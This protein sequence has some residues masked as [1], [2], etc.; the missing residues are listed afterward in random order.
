[1]SPV[2][3]FASVTV[4]GATSPSAVDAK[5]AAASTSGSLAVTAYVAVLVA[6]SAPVTV[7]VI[8]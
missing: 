7:S 6:P 1:M 3:L 5:L 4:T 8:V 2:E